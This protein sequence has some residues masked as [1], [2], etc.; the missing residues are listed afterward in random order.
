MGLTAAIRVSDPGGCPVA[1]ASAATDAAIDDVARGTVSDDTVVEEFSVDA[2]DPP[3]ADLEEV[4]G[5]DD[6]GV[7]RFE[8]DVGRNCVCERIEAF[9]CPV[10][11]VTATNGELRVVVRPD[12]LSTL[13]DM[14]ERLREAYGCVRLEHLGRPAAPSGGESVRV[15]LGRLTDRQRAV[16]ETA[17]ESGYFEHPKGANAEEVAA[18]LDISS[19]T[20]RGHLAAAQTK[21]FE[22][23]LRS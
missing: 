10:T 13:K 6:H 22:E 5:D 11:D 9:G 7:Y 3:L 15:D 1:T 2:A 19:A 21:L 8:R 23:L 14:V 16:L 12:D 18:E 17:T 20:L 4:Y